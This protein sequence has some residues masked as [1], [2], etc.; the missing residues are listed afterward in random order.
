MRDALKQARVSLKPG[1]ILIVTSKAVSYAEGRLASADDFETLR[2]HESERI[3]G[4]GEM[5]MTLKN[6]MLIPNAGIDFSNAPAGQIILWPRDPFFSARRL[7]NAFKLKRLGVLIVDSGLRPLRRG[8][9]GMAIGWAGFEGIEDLR[10][11]KD[12]FGKKM[13]Y[14]QVSVADNLAAAGELVMGSSNA[15]IPFVIVRDVRVIFTNRKF[16]AKDYWMDSK[17]CLYGAH[18]L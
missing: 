18:R 6:K 12:L 4:R 14:S 15:S 10:G 17:K 8:T 13:K 3:F 2:R 7:R 16:S 9:S 1:D 11:T 5:V